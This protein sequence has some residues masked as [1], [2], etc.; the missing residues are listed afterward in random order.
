M[1]IAILDDYPGIAL[2]FGDWAGLGEIT[3]FRDT[4]RDHDALVAR[5]APFEVLCLMRERTPFPGSLLRALPNLRLLVTSGMRNNSI[6]LPAAKELGIMVCGTESRKRTTSE[7]AMTLALTLNRRIIPEARSLNA[8]GWQTGVGRDMEGLT[9]GIVGLGNIGGQMAALG[10]AFGMNVA[11]WSQNLTEARCAEIGAK[12]CES[13]VELMSVSD[14]V[15]VHMLMSE[16]T[17]GL[18]GAEAF[19]AMRPGAVFVNTSRAPI[20]DYDALLAGLRAHRPAMAAL[21]V[22]AVE[23]LPA[24]DPIRDLPL[25]EEGRLLLVPHLGYVTESCM[26]TYIGQT[27]DAVRAWHSGSPI[28]VIQDPA[29]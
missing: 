29:A 25:I 13:L 22:Y 12:R 15:S 27:A 1:K 9:L 28:R 2:D 26:R 4:I 14:V 16:R 7:L 6:D 18:I 3:V 21:D 19:A 8:G 23:P 11:A 10:Q 20:V 24:D 5:L 17:R